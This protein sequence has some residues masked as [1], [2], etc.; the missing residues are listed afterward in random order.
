MVFVDFSEPLK[1]LLCS[2]RDCLFPKICDYC[3]LPFEDGL[4]NVL[5]SSCFLSIRP[6]QEPVCS[7]CGEPLVPGAFAGATLL[8]CSDCGEG[9]YFL[10]GVRAYGDYAGAL[11]IAHHAF[12]FEGMEHL[13][14]VMAECMARKIPESFTAGEVV[15][16]PVPLSPERERERGF[17]P[18]QLLSRHLSTLKGLPVK[19]LLRKIKSIPPQMSLTREERLRNPEGAYEII[20][21]IPMPLGVVLVDDVFTTGATLEECAKVLKRSG[22]Q[23]VFAVVWGRTPRYF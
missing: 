6:Y 13:G 4:S 10:D 21:S 3:G 23:S 11:R 1:T 5:C 15:F 19:E 14:P 9:E 16:C 22:A 18:A 17:N 2:I 7:R 8:R 20:S 12:K